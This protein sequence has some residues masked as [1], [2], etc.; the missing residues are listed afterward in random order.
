VGGFF[1]KRR[2][3]VF[4]TPGGEEN[5][6]WGYLGWEFCN[7]GSLG[8]ILGFKEVGFEIVGGNFGLVEIL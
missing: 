3:G 2:G 6:N 5:P 7:R 1:Q 4:P 8:G